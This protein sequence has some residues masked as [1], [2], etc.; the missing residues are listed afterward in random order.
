[1][2]AANIMQTAEQ[3]YLFLV[4]RVRANLHIVLCFS[5]IGEEFS[6]TKG[7]ESCQYH[8]DRGAVAQKAMKAANIMQTAEQVYLFLVDRV[9][10]NL[11]IVLCFSPIGEEF[12]CEYY[13]SSTKGDE[14]CQHHA[15]RGAGI[16]VPAGPREGQP[17]HRAVLQPHRARVQ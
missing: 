1:M 13:P 3:V 11:H 10:A 14:S 9:L 15:D 4:D 7:D 16:S 5:P 2:K 12:R 17:A 6:S 8:A